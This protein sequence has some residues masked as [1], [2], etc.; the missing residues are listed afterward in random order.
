MAKV[1]NGKKSAQELEK[2]VKKKVGDLEKKFGLTPRL[3]SIVIGEGKASHLYLV[4]QERA[5]ER[6][7]IL[8]G[9]K[10]FSPQASLE[11]IYQYINSLNQDKKVHGIVIQMPLPG[12]FEPLELA[13]QIKPEKDVDCLNPE[14]IESLINGRPVFL[15]AV[16]RAVLLILEKEK[17][18]LKGKK[19]VVVGAS[20]FVGRPLVA[21]LKNLGATVIPCDEYTRDLGKWTKMGEILI[22]AT[23][24][25]GLIKKEMVKK[26]AIVID[27]GSPKAE[28]DFRKVK[29]IASFIT[30]V[31]GG[32][33]PLTI[34]CLLE[35]TLLAFDN[36]RQKR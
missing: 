23:G 18:K 10:A 2:E 36:L 13:G 5:A 16:V 35:N 17:V 27:V 30:P 19:V 32:V 7:G 20:G 24:V 22:S 26:G 15:P 8:F 6:V 33:G 28:V 34:V 1:F 14:N 11:Q 31:P 9:K 29:K 21:H 3:V 25:T 12:K 4:G